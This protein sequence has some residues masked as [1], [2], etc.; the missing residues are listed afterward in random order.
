VATRDQFDQPAGNF[1]HS[2]DDEREV[3]DRRPGQVRTKR[4]PGPSVLQ[5]MTRT[6]L[7][8]VGEPERHG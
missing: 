2:A 5:F 4:N 1:S 3:I 7:A 6:D 8:S